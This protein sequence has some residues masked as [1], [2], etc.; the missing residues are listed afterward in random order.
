MV[1]LLVTDITSKSAELLLSFGNQ[2]DTDVFSRKNLLYLS[3]PYLEMISHLAFP[4]QEWLT[5]Y[6]VLTSTTFLL[7]PLIPAQ[8]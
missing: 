2:E 4:D 1:I 5:S 6:T 7:L 3:A 8:H